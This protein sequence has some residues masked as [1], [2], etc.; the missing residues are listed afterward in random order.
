MQAPPLRRQACTR[1]SC[2]VSESALC[3]DRLRGLPV[4]SAASRRERH[5][6]VGRRARRRGRGRAG[7]RA[8][9]RRRAGYRA[10]PGAWELVRGRGRRGA[11]QRD[12]GRLARAHAARRAAVRRRRRRGRGRPGQVRVGQPEPGGRGPRAQLPQRGQRG[13]GPALRPDPAPLLSA[14]SPQAASL[15]PHSPAPAPPRLCACG[16]RPLGAAV[17]HTCAWHTDP[18]VWSNRGSGGVLSIL[19]SIFH[20]AA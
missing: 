7:G 3:G 18:H 11:R 15:A 20:G 6:R 17:R 12:A 5:A 16:H 10:E 2:T 4:G 13:G 8:A 14:P 9:A 19:K 1:F